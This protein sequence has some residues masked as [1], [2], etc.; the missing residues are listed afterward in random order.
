LSLI[1]GTSGVL[2]FVNSR[3][4]DHESVRTV[5]LEEPGALIVPMGIMAEIGYMFEQRLGLRALDAFINDL[6][7]GQF[8]L[9]SGLEDIPRVRVLVNRSSSLPLGFADEVV[10]AC[11]ERFLKQVLTLDQQHFTVVGR[12]VGLELLP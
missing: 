8:M 10:L 4:P 5:I 7:A 1:L 12:E 2:A 11:A 3:D 6:E 9:D